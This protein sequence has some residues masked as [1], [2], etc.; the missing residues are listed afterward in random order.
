MP[1]SVDADCSYCTLIGHTLGEKYI[2]KRRRG[3]KEERGGKRL[4]DR[5]I[6]GEREW[7]M[8]STAVIKQ[9]NDLSSRKTHSN[10]DKRMQTW[11]W[12][13]STSSVL[14]KQICHRHKTMSNS[15]CDRP[16]MQYLNS[17]MINYVS[18]HR[19]NYLR[20][21]ACRSDFDLSTLL[22]SNSSTSKN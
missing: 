15:L 10:T 4:G 13:R 11:I 19:Q 18:L 1:K 21:V 7:E 22:R 14:F 3:K 17:N 16:L 9:S 20:N 6:K 8:K 5:E 2:Y 12:A